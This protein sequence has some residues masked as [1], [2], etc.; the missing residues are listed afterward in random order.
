MS[1]SLG[2]W[3]AGESEGVAAAVLR[4]VLNYHDSNT[5]YCS[6]C[7]VRVV[8]VPE[9]APRPPR[10]ASVRLTEPRGA[11]VARL[12]PRRGGR[13]LLVYPRFQLVR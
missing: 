4:V 10:P 8:W 3:M 9:M 12:V 7:S 13:S 2:C 1:S 5:E 11:A 6:I